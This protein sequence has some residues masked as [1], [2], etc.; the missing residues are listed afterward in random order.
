[1]VLVNGAHLYSAFIQ[2]SLQ[3]LTNIHPFMYTFTHR[4]RRQLSWSGA[5]RVRRL[6][7]GHNDTQ[8]T[9]KVLGPPIQPPT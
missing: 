5:V 2:S 6:A 3:C 8:G 7:Q 1:M 4:Q 9:S